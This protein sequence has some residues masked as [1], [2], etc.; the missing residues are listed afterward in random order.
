MSAGSVA[1]VVTEEIEVP[2][3][4]L[5][6]LS[7]PCTVFGKPQPDLADPWYDLR[8]CGTGE[9]SPDGRSGPA[10]SG[11]TVR[12]DYGLDGLVGAD[13]VIVP[14]V[15]DSCVEEGTPLPAELVAALRRA[16]A[17]GAR[18]V[19]LCTGAFALALDRAGRVMRS[20]CRP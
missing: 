15:P 5:Y 3:W 8:L 4:D 17:A 11:L 6:E 1:V 2:S 9:P 14:S 10:G 7:I 20:V 13:T 19:S 16:H 18:I 12:T